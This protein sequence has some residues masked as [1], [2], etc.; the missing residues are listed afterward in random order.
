MKKAGHER[1]ESMKILMSFRELEEGE[2]NKRE[3]S[4]RGGKCKEL[5]QV[6]GARTPQ[7]SF[8]L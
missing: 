4:G 2:G 7:F 8:Q 5:E 1:Y 6:L 3:S